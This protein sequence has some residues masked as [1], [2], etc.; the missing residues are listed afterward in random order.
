MRIRPSPLGDRDQSEYT[1]QRLDEAIAPRGRPRADGHIDPEDPERHPQRNERHRHGTGQAKGHDAPADDQ[2]RMLRALDPRIVKRL[3]HPRGGV[4]VQRRQRQL[5]VLTQVAIAAQ[6]L[7][8][9]V[10][11]LGL[12]RRAGV[13]AHLAEQTLASEPSDR[14]VQ[15]RE[16]ARKLQIVP[17]LLIE[18]QQLIAGSGQGKITIG[19]PCILLARLRP[20]RADFTQQPPA[21]EQRFQPNRHA[22]PYGRKL[23][24]A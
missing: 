1:A 4:R 7:K 13:G 2:S 10:E 16:D 18:V 23:A 17:R 12:C 6:R 9:L 15:L 22:G 14:R 3:D 8:P 24:V 21:R 20:A 19:E 11:L 5:N